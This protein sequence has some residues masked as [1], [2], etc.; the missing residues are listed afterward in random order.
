VAPSA[1]NTRIIRSACIVFAQVQ[2]AIPSFTL[3]S[4][5]LNAA[6]TGVVSYLDAPVTLAQSQSYTFNDVVYLPPSSYSSPAAVNYGMIF[7]HSSGS[8]AGV[9]NCFA[10]YLETAVL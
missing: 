6:G 4:V 8:G 1:T 2:S 5:L 7:S 10:S 9:L 3:Q